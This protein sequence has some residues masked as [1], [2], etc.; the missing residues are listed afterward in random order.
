MNNK[1]QTA[2]PGYKFFAILSVISITATL[3]CAY[4]FLPF[5]TLPN[6]EAILG[7][8]GFN[9]ALLGI[10]GI[11]L[12]RETIEYNWNQRV[13]AGACTDTLILIMFGLFAVAL[14]SS[15]SLTPILLIVLGACTSDIFI[16]QTILRKTEG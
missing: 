12:G 10:V 6:T 11:A 15:L 9:A 4:Y 13:L 14:F 5:D 2:S 16:R 1:Q 7:I 8:T 3:W